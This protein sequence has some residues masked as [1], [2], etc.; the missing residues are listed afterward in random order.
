MKMNTIG[1]STHDKVNV[2]RVGLAV[3]LPAPNIFKLNDLRL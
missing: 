3:A 1:P 2:W